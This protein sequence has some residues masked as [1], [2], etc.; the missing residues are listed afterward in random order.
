MSD[1]RLRRRHGIDKYRVGEPLLQKYFILLIWVVVHFYGA[2]SAAQTATETRLTNL[3]PP[4]LDRRQAETLLQISL[5]SNPLLWPDWSFPLER[6]QHDESRDGQALQALVQAGVLV[7]E[8]FVSR[9]ESAS[10]GQ[11]A[12]A[13]WRYDIAQGQEEWRTDEGKWLIYGY[14]QVQKIRYV[15][16]AY[17]VDQYWYLEAG[18]EWFVDKPASWLNL[19]QI[20]HLRLARRALQSFDKPFSR[21]VF[22]QFDGQ[23]WGYW[24]AAVPAPAGSAAPVRSPDN[25]VSKS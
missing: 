5:F 4:S 17:P 9:K 10:G 25:P 13:G 14:G 23:R 7:R 12:V 6:I 2:K 22:F 1:I 24:Q 15:S 19:P 18:L 8:A 11:V 20:R 16:E 21:S 3:Q